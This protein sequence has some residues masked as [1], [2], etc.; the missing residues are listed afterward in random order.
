MHRAMQHITA[1]MSPQT[2]ARAAARREHSNVLFELQEAR[3]RF[4]RL[5]IR[6]AQLLPAAHAARRHAEAQ[7]R[8]QQRREVTRQQIRD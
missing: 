1:G 6:E 4:D 2:A 5:L 8:R 3:E 7:E